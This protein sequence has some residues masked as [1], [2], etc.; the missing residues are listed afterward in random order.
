MKLEALNGY[1]M[2]WSSTQ[3]TPNQKW[4][5]EEQWKYGQDSFVCMNMLNETKK[6]KKKKKKISL[7]W[8]P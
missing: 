7:T 5:E 8:N 4:H 1:K 6:K 3:P 2:Q